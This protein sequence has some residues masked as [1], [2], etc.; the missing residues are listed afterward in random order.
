M[1][2]RFLRPL[3]KHLEGV[4]LSNKML[5]HAQADLVEYLER[6]S[7]PFD[8]I[9]AADTLNYFGDLTDVMRL[10]IQSIRPGGY[11]L[12]TVKEGP[13]MGDDGYYLQPHGRYVH[14]PPHII[15]RM[16]ENG[17][18]GGTMRRIVLRKEND[19]DVMGLMTLC[20]KPLHDPDSDE[21][22]LLD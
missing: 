16:G 1:V 21:N 13:L 9:V 12:F 5:E 18:P 4:D 22:Q 17:I 20:Q 2:G 11:L 6:L 15:E 14:T 7:E 10:L 8:L 3:A 19:K